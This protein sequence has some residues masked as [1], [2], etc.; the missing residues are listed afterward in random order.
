MYT[1]TLIFLAACAAASQAAFTL[2]TDGGDGIWIHTVNADGSDKVERVGDI[3]RT[4]KAPAPPS[5]KVRRQG[6]IS[7]WQIGCFGSEVSYALISS[8]DDVANFR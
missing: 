1:K 8:A 6:A 2:P 3:D 4:L 7:N 5:A